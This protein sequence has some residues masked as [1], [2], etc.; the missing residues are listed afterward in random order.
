M[1]ESVKKGNEDNSYFSSFQR[2]ILLYLHPVMTKTAA[3]FF[4]SIYLL[5]ATE[6]HQLFKL[7]VIFAH[8]KEHKKEDSSITFMRFL[9]IH[10]MHGSPKDKDY[11]R[12]MQLPFKTS[13]DCASSVSPAFVPFFVQHA[14]PA[15]IELTVKNTAVTQNQFLLSSYLA[16]IWQPPKFC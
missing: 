4:L 14:A 3:I 8:F 2:A 7:P 13:A 11:D 12:D 6:A 16:S 9:D 5:S 1:A 15:P 10:Y